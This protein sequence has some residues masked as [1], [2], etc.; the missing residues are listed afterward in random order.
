MINIKSLLVYQNMVL[1]CFMII[2]IKT[3]MDFVDK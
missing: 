2:M 3:H 1:L